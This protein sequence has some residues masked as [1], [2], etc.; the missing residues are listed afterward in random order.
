MNR[1]A[2]RIVPS[3]RSRGPRFAARAAAAALLVA[4]GVGHGAESAVAE[5]PSFRRDV[6]PVFFRA[7]CNAGTCHGSARGKD[8]FMLSLFGYDAKGD[9]ARIVEQL[10][11]R[12]VNT[13]VPERSLLLLKATAAVPHTGGKL[14]DVESDFYRTL[15]DWVAAGAPD[16]DGAVPEM[17]DVVLSRTS[18]VFET[19]GP[20]EPLGVTA[21]YADGSSRDVTRL[22]RYFSNNASVAEIDADGGVTSKGPGDTNVFA[23]FGRFTVGAEVIVLPPAEGFAWPN[24]PAD[25]FIDRLVFDRLEKLRIVPSGLCDDET[26]L[27]R[28]TLDLAARPPTVDEYRAFMADA[29]ADKRTRRIDELLAGDEFIDLWTMIWS[30]QMRIIG[31]SYAPQGTLVKS[32]DAFQEW[33][34]AQFAA[35]RPL[36]EFVAEMVAASGSNIAAGPPNFYTMMVHKPALEPKQLAADFSQLLLGVQIQCA[37]CHNHPFDRWTMDDYYSFVSFFSGIRRINGVEPRE[38]RIFFD[39]TSEPARHLVDGRPMPARVLG[40]VQPEP[41]GVD[42]RKALAAWLTAPDNRLFREN[43]ANRIWAQLMGRG[44]VDPVDDVRVSNP[45]SNPALF[46]ALGSRLAELKFDLRGLVRDICSSRVYQ[47]ST[48]PTAS[49]ALDT[50]QFSHAHLRRLRADV[51]MD[52]IVAITGVPGRFPN[53]PVGARAIETHPRQQGDTGNGAHLEPFFHTFGQATRKTVAAAETKREPTLAQAL[54][55][56][57]GDTVRDRLAAGG[58]VKALVETK[59]TPEDIVEE[60]FIR[61]LARKPDGEEMAAMIALVG[62][63]PKDPAVYEDIFWSLLNSTEFLFNH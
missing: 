40:G 34:H 46:E 62:D 8:G 33:V 29:S 18:F 42:P 59:S 58:V 54:H 24:P 16:D 55:L 10:P 23:R 37:E 49:N 63:S 25:T 28:V 21:V 15:R 35:G 47:L 32:A 48:Q 14:F 61:V 4:G 11:G 22:A 19:A 50:R 38:K 36:N 44:V 57:V 53:F 45:P 5:A 39:T 12:R 52:S 1:P 27:R 41:G 9:Y 2:P 3:V 30:E 60:L 20:S 7:G 56:I 31:G 26:F 17:V 6:M 51:L 13:A 43:L